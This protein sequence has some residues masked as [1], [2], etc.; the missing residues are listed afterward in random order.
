MMAQRTQSASCPSVTDHCHVQLHGQGVHV[1]AN[2]SGCVTGWIQNK[3]NHWYALLAS[4]TQQLR[5]T[6]FKAQTRKG[7]TTS[8]KERGGY[9]EHMI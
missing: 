7:R 9:P 1:N 5:P 6:S 2:S 3:A 8:E 4:S